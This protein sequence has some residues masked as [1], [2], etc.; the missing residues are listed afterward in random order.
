VS[1]SPLRACWSRSAIQNDVAEGSCSEFFFVG[2]LIFVGG[3]FT[4]DA[5]GVDGSFGVPRELQHSIAER[6]SESSLWYVLGVELS[7]EEGLCISS[8]T[9]QAEL[10]SA[11][12][13]FDGTP[14][15]GV[16]SCPVFSVTISFESSTEGFLA[17]WLTPSAMKPRLPIRVPVARKES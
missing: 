5:T 3:V 9:S 12:R 10:K 4:G 16:V 2:V 15:I 1:F 6:P 8:R 14:P 13:G 17:A 7:S 11:T